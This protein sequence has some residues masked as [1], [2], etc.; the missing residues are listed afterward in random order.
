[1]AITPGVVT[2][3]TVTEN[4]ASLTSAVATGGTGPYSYQWYKSTVTGFTPGPGNIIAGATSLSITDTGLVPGTQYFYKM[5][6]TDSAPTPE[7]G[8]SPSASVLTLPQ[9]LNVN[10]FAM[11]PYL[12]MLDQ[13]FNYNTSPVVVDSAVVTPLQNGQAVKMVDSAG[14]SP[15]V[16][17]CTADADQ[18]FGFINYN[19]KNAFFPA[20]TPCEI[21]RDGNVMYLRSTGAIA[22][23]ARVVVNVATIG[24]V[25]A[26]TGSSGKRIVGYAYDKAIQ[27]GQ[28]IRVVVGTPS[29]TLDS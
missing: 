4:S 12:G 18:V 29:W 21:S 16:V 20:N 9:T 22:R 14:G 5:V 23:G 2:V 15:K 28:L 17:A 3:N 1:M 13:H 19:M 6:S 27:A 7:E 10:Q 8:I 24:G 25:A 11:A 26:A